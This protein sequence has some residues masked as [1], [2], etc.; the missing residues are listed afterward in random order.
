MPPSTLQ[1]ENPQN[2]GKSHVVTKGPCHPKSARVLN[3]LST[4]DDVVELLAVKI[5]AETILLW[6]AGV[7]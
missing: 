2:D 3:H 5:D 7:S 4:V 1:R 6:M